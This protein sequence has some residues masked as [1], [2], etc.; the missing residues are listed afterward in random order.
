MNKYPQTLD[1]FFAKH[2]LLASRTPEGCL[3]P[4]LKARSNSGGAMVSFKGERTYFHILRMR[5]HLGTDI[6]E[7]YLVTHVCDRLDCMEY[8]HLKL[9]KKTDID[10]KPI[11]TEPRHGE[12]SVKSKLTESNVRDIFA[13]WDGG[14]SQKRLAEE[15]K[16]CTGTINNI[17]HGKRWR[18]L[19]LEPNRAVKNVDRSSHSRNKIDQG[20]ADEIRQKITEGATVAEI[21]KEYGISSASI[22]HIKKGNTW[23]GNVNGNS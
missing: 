9:S 2:D 14:Y 23:R 13:K 8:T 18:H 15:Y 5:H 7:G 12:L 1:E 21:S 10:K 20:K 17:L 11:L 6:P 16:V 4:V 19:G 22:Y 3:I